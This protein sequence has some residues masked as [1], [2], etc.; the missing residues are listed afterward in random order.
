MNLSRLYRNYGWPLTWL[1][2]AVALV[3]I[4]AMSMI[5]PHIIRAAIGG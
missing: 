2:E 4:V 1:G 3:V 5:L